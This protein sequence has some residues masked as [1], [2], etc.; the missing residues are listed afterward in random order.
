VRI[1][2]TFLVPQTN[3]LTIKLYLHLRKIGFEPMCKNYLKQIY[4]LLLST[5][6]ATFPNKIRMVGFEPTTFDAQ[7][8][9]STTELHPVLKERE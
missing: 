1:E 6:S 9:Y 2:R 3:T 5:N 7:D 4:S 8:Q